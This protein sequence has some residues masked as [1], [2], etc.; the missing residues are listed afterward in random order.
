MLMC[1]STIS[2]DRLRSDFQCAALL[3]QPVAYT[4]AEM[5]C[6]AAWLFPAAVHVQSLKVRVRLA[7]I[8]RNSPAHISSIKERVDVE[9]RQDKESSGVMRCLLP[10]K[11]EDGRAFG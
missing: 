1:A 4:Y 7:V 9:S 5:S 8:C 3:H 10:Q 2:A 11:V 6:H